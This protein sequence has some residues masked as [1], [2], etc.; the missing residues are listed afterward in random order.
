MTTYTT[1]KTY[2]QVFEDCKELTAA[3]NAKLG[4]DAITIELLSEGKAK[5]VA[6]QH[7]RTMS[8]VISLNDLHMALNGL[9][10]K[11]YND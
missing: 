4:A 7:G 1:T 10:H 2:E 5:M 11:V 3:I 8:N 6:N 9:K